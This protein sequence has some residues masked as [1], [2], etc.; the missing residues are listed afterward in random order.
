M[1]VPDEIVEVL[2]PLVR[3]PDTITTWFQAHEPEL[4]MSPARWLEAGRDPEAVVEQAR[5][6]ASVLAH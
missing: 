1:D 5:R 2:A 3:H 6:Y 4:G